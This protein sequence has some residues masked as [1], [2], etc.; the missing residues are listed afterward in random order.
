M[1]IIGEM[2]RHNTDFGLKEVAEASR[3]VGCP[4]CKTQ[5]R[6]VEKGR[7]IA[8]S[9]L[10]PSAAEV[11]LMNEERGVFRIGS[12]IAAFFT[13]VKII[14]LSLMIRFFLFDFVL[15]IKAFFFSGTQYSRVELTKHSHL[16]D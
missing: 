7:A 9:Q 1:G 2:H 11:G 6:V 15:F 8:H 3:G 12:E 13:Q 16:V 10:T 4:C 14:I 5:Y